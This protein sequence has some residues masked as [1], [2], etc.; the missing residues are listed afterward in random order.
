MIKWFKK[1][2]FGIKFSLVSAVVIGCLMFLCIGCFVVALILDPYM[3]PSFE[4]A[5]TSPTSKSSISIKGTTSSSVTKATLYDKDNKKLDETE[6]NNSGKFVF[7]DVK[8]NKGSNSF[9]VKVVKSNGK[10]AK[11]SITI[12]RK[13][14]KKTKEKKE[15]V[16]TEKKEKEDDADEQPKATTKTINEH[17]EK[18][19]KAMLDD[20]DISAVEIDKANGFI[21]VVFRSDSIWDENDAVFDCCS[22]AKTYMPKLF[23]I[24]GVQ[25]V[26]VSIETPFS[27]AYG[28]DSWER[29]VT[30]D[31]T[32]SEAEKVEWSKINS[33]NRAGIIK[34]AE[35]VYIHPAVMK[36]VDSDDILEALQYQQLR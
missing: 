11:K 12:V 16:K 14:A 5:Y 1:Q 9:T 18:T 29:A 28:K 22:N 34:V 3:A 10:T 4:L 35:I 32:K 20:S 19:I 27:D 2:T 25:N 13:E 26:G 33:L 24:S 17:T 6:P 30:I 21:D 7:N 8:L 23:K 15:E 31:L 36:N